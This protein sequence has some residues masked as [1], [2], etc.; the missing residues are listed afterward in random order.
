MTTLSFRRKAQI[1]KGANKTCVVSSRP[2]LPLHSFYPGSHTTFFLI[3][4]QESF[5]M[6][7]QRAQTF[8]LI[9]ASRKV[10]KESCALPSHPIKMVASSSCFIALAYSPSSPLR[11]VHC[12]YLSRAFSVFP[13]DVS[14]TDQLINFF[15]THILVLT[16]S[17][18]LQVRA[19]NI[20]AGLIVSPVVSL[21]PLGLCLVCL[22]SQA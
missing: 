18:W 12:I 21:N 17:A 6:T 7:I 4:V 3:L 5:W 20:S 8:S 11:P 15:D 9:P 13:Q 14:F 10:T 16:N 22:H 19:V 1:F 2:F